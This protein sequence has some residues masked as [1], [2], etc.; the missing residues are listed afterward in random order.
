[1]H[2]EAATG[3]HRLL[4][5]ALQDPQRVSRPPSRTSWHARTIVETVSHELSKIRNALVSKVRTSRAAL[6]RRTPTSAAA[7]PHNSGCA[8]S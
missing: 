1:M 3:Y 5:E 8:S 4:R 7:A 6:L 2:R